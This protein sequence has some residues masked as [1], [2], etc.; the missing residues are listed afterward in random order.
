MNSSLKNNPPLIA[1]M[2]NKCKEN[3]RLHSI[4]NESASI[5]LQ[6]EDDYYNYIIDNIFNRSSQHIYE[7][8]EI[9]VIAPGGD[10]EFFLLNIHKNI[11]ID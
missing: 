7:P 5:F 4:K 6:D 2:Y 1:Y 10:Q 11:A 9:K 8:T 3:I